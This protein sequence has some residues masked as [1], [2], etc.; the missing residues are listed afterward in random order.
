MEGSLAESLLKLRRVA[1]GESNGDVSEKLLRNYSVSARKS[2]D[3]M[4]HGA[5]VVSGFEGGRS[6]C[7]G[8]FHGSITGGAETGRRSLCEDKQNHLLQ[9]D[10]KLGASYSPDSPRNGMVRFYLTPLRSHVTSNSGKS[11]LINYVRCSAS[12][13]NGSASKRTTLHDLYEK[14]GQ[15]PWYDNLCRPVTDLLPFIARGVRGVTSNPAIF[16]KTISTSD[17]YKISSEKL[18]A[19][20]EMEHSSFTNDNHASFILAEK[21]HTLANQD[22]RVT[23][24]GYSIPHPSLECVNVRNL[25]VWI[26]QKGAITRTYFLRERKAVPTC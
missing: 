2:C 9:R 4:F 5:Y 16:Q 15:S 14:E 1:K 6:S 17:A 20:G 10:D 11:R 24:A 25:F 21:D 7:D 19:E 8:L 23:L 12:S 3:G 22:P 18:E 26:L 13:G